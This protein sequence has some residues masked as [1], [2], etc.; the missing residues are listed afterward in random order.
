MYIEREIQNQVDSYLK[1]FKVVLITGARQVGKSTML[2][3]TLPKNYTYVS[4]D[5]PDVLSQI[6]NDSALFFIENELPIVIDEIQYAPELFMRVKNIVDKS[7]D[8][9]NVVLTG[10]QSYH[11]MQGVSESLAGRIGILELSSLSLREIT[12]QLKHQPFIPQMIEKANINKP[13][14]LNLWKHIQRGSMPELANPEIDSHAYYS[15]YVRTYIERDVRNITKVHSEV[16]FY[17]FMVACAARTGQLL[18][19]TDLAKSIQVDVTT[20]QGWLSILSASGIIHI[21]RPFWTNTKKR[22]AKTPKLFFMDT[23]LACY[24]A[25]W[26]SHEALR[27]S[28]MAGHMFETFV[29]SEIL[30]SYLNSGRDLREISF[31][32][33]AQKREIDLIVRQGNTL[34]P[35]EIKTAASV[36]REAIKNFDALQGFSE[37]EV[38]FSSVICQTD[39][40]YLLTENVQ[41]IPVWA[42]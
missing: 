24:L 38:G 28:A 40:P 7:S 35:I 42:L 31:Y 16:K 25:A 3:H 18:N 4:L 22:L 26:N 19:A 37:Y 30:K 29:V 20:I 32:R 5:N 10:S 23:G 27:R 6:K 36:K 2:Q 33:D 14:G 39:E 15:S 34:Y 8:K 9:G 41:A 13:K 11:L 1:Q 21:L 12:G 17:D